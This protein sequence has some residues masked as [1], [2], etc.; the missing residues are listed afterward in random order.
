[1][2]NFILE[3]WFAGAVV[4][5][6]WAFGEAQKLQIKRKKQVNALTIENMK[7]TPLK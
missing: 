2:I 7:N 3:Y 5:A 6:F 1:M 4:V